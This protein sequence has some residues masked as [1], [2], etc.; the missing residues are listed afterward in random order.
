MIEDFTQPNSQL[1][2]QGPETG[3][4]LETPPVEIQQEEAE[5]IDYHKKWLEYYEKEEVKFDDVE[6][7]ITRRSRYNNLPASIGIGGEILYLDNLKKRRDT[8]AGR[9]LELLLKT[10]KVEIIIKTQMQTMGIKPEDGKDFRRLLYQETLAAK[11]Y[12]K[13]VGFTE[14]M[15]EIIQ[16]GLKQK[17]KYTDF[18]Q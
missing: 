3:G 5:D 18:A 9:A 12:Q 17:F 11:E 16:E 6:P 2:D 13:L 8:L 7:E 10:E 4:S 14:K 1:Q 15:E